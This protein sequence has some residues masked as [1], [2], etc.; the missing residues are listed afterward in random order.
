MTRHSEQDSHHTRQLKYTLGLEDSRDYLSRR[1]EVTQATFPSPGDIFELRWF[2]SRSEAR[3]KIILRNMRARFDAF[4]HALPTLC[5]HFASMEPRVRV[6]ICHWH[7]QLSDPI[8]RNFTGDY[9]PERLL[10]P[11]GGVTLEVVVTWLEEL[12]PGRWQPITTRS[13]ASKLMSTAY[14]AG[15]LD[16]T[17][18]QRLVLIP[19]VPDEALEYLLY[20][21]RDLSFTGSLLDNP[22]LRSVGLDGFML[23]DRLRKLS[24][25]TLYKQG[26]LLDFQW[27]YNDL[28]EWGNASP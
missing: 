15:L 4:P 14:Q 1:G 2:G 17:G 23:E 5:D 13:L 18:E 19:R 6:L 10:S 12:Y 24:G 3:V 9:L 27:S 7:T 25:V 22:Y 16:K 28:T 11:S 20:L 26:D 21:L 8:Y